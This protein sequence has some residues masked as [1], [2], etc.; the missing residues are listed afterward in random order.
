MLS[1]TLGYELNIEIGLYITIELTRVYTKV[2]SIIY[3]P[4][5]DF[6]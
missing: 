1:D 4:G 5:D 2:T 6:L 3:R